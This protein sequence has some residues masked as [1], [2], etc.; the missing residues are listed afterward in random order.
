MPL[1]LWTIEYKIIKVRIKTAISIYKGDEKMYTNTVAPDRPLTPSELVFLNGEQFAQKVMLG[2]I[3]LLH[4]EA[5]VSQVQLGMAILEAAFLGCEEAGAISLGIGERKA[6][7]GLRKVRELYAVPG[8]EEVRLPADS[9]EAEFAR[10]AQRM[11][12]RDEHSVRNIV[13]A[14]LREDTRSPWNNA[15]DL[16]KAGMAQRGLLDEREEK[17]LKIF[18][19][20]HYSLAGETSQLLRGQSFAP[21]KRLLESCQGSRP[22]IWKMLESGIKKAI[23]A[24]TEQDD[25]S[26]D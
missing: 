15:M 11:E 26:S 23:S 4:T 16:F 18:T 12:E 21:V 5:K 9:L 22:E 17:K 13:Y 25:T 6:L 1:C 3:D 24:R 14:W 10:L 2:N 7:F 8:S 19:V 20:K